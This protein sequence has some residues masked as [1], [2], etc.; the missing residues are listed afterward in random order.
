M[1]HNMSRSQKWVKFDKEY[2]SYDWTSDTK[3]WIP[4]GEGGDLLVYKGIWKYR[5]LTKL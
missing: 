4:G 5:F 2:F 3:I 1:S